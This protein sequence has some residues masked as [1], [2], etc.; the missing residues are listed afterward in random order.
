[1]G[2]FTVIALHQSKLW[3]SRITEIVAEAFLFIKSYLFAGTGLA[4]AAPPFTEIDS[5]VEEVSA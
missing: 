2:R 5:V 3:I 1:M 4:Q